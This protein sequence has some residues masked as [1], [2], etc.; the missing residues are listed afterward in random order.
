LSELARRDGLTWDSP[1][2]VLDV[3]RRARPELVEVVDDAWL[4]AHEESAESVA[5]WRAA[6][7]RS[8]LI[9][10]LSVADR[11]LGAITLLAVDEQ[12]DFSADVRTLAAKFATHASLALENAR[13]YRV[14]QEATEGR[15]QVLGVVSHDLRNPI[16]AIAMCASALQSS[17][18]ISSE[19]RESLLLT[20]TQSTQWM[21]RLI[22]D[23]LDVASIE[24][25]RLSLERDRASVRTLVTGA[26]RMF[27]GEALLRTIQ[28]AHEVRSD[29]PPV[30]ADSTRIVQV[31]GNLLGNAL[32]FTPDGGRITVS[33]E[34][35][36]RDV[37]IT[38]SDT[39]A[40]IPLE[41]Q[42]LVFDRYW[43]ARRSASKRGTGL[44]LSIAKGIVQAHGG[45]IWLESAP[46]RGSTFSFSLP[47]DTTPVAVRRT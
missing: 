40:G 30:M 21:N 5:R 35:R 44:G 2:P 38:V 23:L 45:R 37:V 3:M 47:V 14:A 32:K 9:V 17:A 33:A 31:L 39:G 42:P 6:G 26:L 1:S 43:H 18:T 41:E 19:K 12:R 25:G 16:S 4:E 27:E 15:D 46:G 8:M 11:T 36:G 20:I 29:L 22:Q 34:S 7:V 13:L 10:P 24:A 28:L